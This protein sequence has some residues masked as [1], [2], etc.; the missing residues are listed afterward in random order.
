DDLAAA[1]AARGAIEK[2]GLRHVTLV[3][4]A[5]EV[6]TEHVLR[7][8]SGGK[9][10]RIELL[11]ERD[12]AR[13]RLTAVE[14]LIGTARDELKA[15]RTTLEEARKASAVALAALRD[16]DAQLAAKTEKLNRAR[17]GVEAALA[18]AER[19]E[20]GLALATSAVDE[21][22]AAHASAV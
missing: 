20:R 14:A 2:A 8:G 9:Q 22:L 12:A 11:A 5:G 6:L 3:T 16:F 4:K 7:G 19:L 10:G 21:A 15:K 18:E 1:R 17:V 13:E